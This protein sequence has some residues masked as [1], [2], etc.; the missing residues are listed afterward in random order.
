MTTN[1]FITSLIDLYGP[2]TSEGMAKAVVTRIQPLADRQR[3]AL[4]DVYIRTVP[5][6]FKPDLKTILECIEKAGIKTEKQKYCPACNYAW[7]GTMHE[8]PRCAYM[9]S[10]GDPKVYHKEWSEGYGRF[11]RMAINEL[12]SNFG[13]QLHSKAS[14]IEKGEYR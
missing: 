4:F 11:N 1:E 3:D 10:D 9:P 14:D 6:N 5:G 8:C 2:F 13:R 12:L 7:H